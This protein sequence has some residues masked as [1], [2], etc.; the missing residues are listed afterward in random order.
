M[1]VKAIVVRTTR[2]TT[3]TQA[4][5]RNI[6]SIPAKSLLIAFEDFNVNAK[7]FM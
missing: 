2:H 5:D 4:T 3:P 6:L 1:N 7:A